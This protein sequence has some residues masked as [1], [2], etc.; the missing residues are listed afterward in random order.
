VSIDRLTPLL[1][2]FQPRANVFFSGQLCESYVDEATRSV[3]HIHW[4]FEGEMDLLINGQRTQR[5]NQPSIVFL[6]K[7]IA[8][9]LVPQPVAEILCCDLEFGHRES[10]PLA[11]LP[12]EVIVIQTSEVTEFEALGQLIY[13]EFMNNRCG[14][15][16][17]LTQLMQ[18]FVLVLLRH[19]ISTER[20]SSGITRALADPR[21]LRAVTAMHHYPGQDWNLE[22][23]AA[24]AGM[25]RSVFANHFR[26]ATGQTPLD[27][28]TD[29]RLSICK[30]MLMAGDSVKQIAH[31]VGYGSSAA[32]IRAFQR[33][34]GCSPIQ[35]ASQQE[36]IH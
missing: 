15:Q 11:L 17:G 22:R 28:L 36:S 16:F 35:W 3:G 32:L 18:Y 27:Y 2:R 21:L 30:S 24:Q 20:L 26:Q 23:L 9:T 4:L 6:P 10:N 8:H 33:K 19:L 7:P 5:I 13:A 25:S 34:V 14:Q 1:T 29:W 31:A 12:S